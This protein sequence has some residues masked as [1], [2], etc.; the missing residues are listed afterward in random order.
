MTDVED[1]DSGFAIGGQT[2]SSTDAA[3]QLNVI[4]ICESF[5]GTRFGVKAFA[6]SARYSD[7]LLCR[8]S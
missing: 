8:F 1:F 2:C 5:A 4:R 3:A 7:V 6:A